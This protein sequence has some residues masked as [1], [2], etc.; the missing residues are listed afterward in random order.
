MNAKLI[1]LRKSKTREYF[2]I[3]LTENY[4]RAYKSLDVPFSIKEW[5]YKKQ[6]L[7]GVKPD[8]ES[9]KYN[10]YI[11]SRHFVESIET[12]YNN[13]INKLVLTKKPFSFNRVFEIVENPSLGSNTMYEVFKLKIKE[14]QDDSKYGT[15]NVYQGT[16]NKL[17]EFHKQDLLFNEVDSQFLI[18]FRNKM[19][20]VSNATKN[21][22]LR[23]IRTVFRYAIKKRIAEQNDYPFIDADI[24]KGTA[25]GYKSRAIS[26]NEVNKIRDLKSELEKGSDM[27]H[28]CNYFIFGYVS[29]GMNFGDI[30]RLK[31]ENR[32]QGRIHF[33]RRKTQ[34]K[35]Q[36]EL[37]VDIT[38]E[39]ADVIRWYRTH[40]VQLNS[41]YL[42]PILNGFHDTELKKYNRINKV[43]KLV[44]DQLKLI[45]DK[46]GS[47]ILLTTYVWRHTF[48]SVAK[49]ELKADVSVI[50]EMM[51][52]QDIKTTKAYLKQFPNEIKDKISARL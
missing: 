4:K 35:V 27:W 22:H 18:N 24:W 39:M 37:S 20:K 28:A 41:P 44:N 49:N 30:A 48:A 42:F 51:G 17:K 14:L 36:D 47:E 43:R 2:V 52:H 21:I 5:N 23:N 33:I 45:G 32:R 25:T 19:G 50:S 34:A 12:K 7:I 15:A 31:L 13:A 8:K 46:I 3:R 16:L 6:I 38:P 1:L 9:D 40:D 10:N 26:M 11:T 29:G